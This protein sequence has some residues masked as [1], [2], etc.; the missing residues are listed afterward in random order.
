LIGYFDDLFNVSTTSG[1][2]TQRPWF[3]L[4]QESFAR[5]SELGGVTFTYEPHDN[6]AVLQT[7]GGV[8]GVR[9]DVRLGGAL[10]DGASGTLAYT[11]AQQHT[12]QY[13]RNQLHSNPAN[14]Y[15]QLRNTIMHE[16]EG[17]WPAHRAR[18]TCC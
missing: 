16:R 14:N 10:V 11:C 1:N 13:G 7:S 2:L 8:L 18:R 5:W 3:H 15:R 6:G 9:G 12:D 17:V 4:F